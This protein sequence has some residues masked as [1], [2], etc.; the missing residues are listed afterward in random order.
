MYKVTIGE[1]NEITIEECVS[2]NK[3]KHVICFHVGSISWF[4][5]VELIKD[6][7]ELKRIWGII[8]AILE[9]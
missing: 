2:L 5:L 6:D 3:Y 9:S 8:N 1:S 7:R 4:D